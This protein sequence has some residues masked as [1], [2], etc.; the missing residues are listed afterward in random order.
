MASGVIP[1]EREESAT[2][3]GRVTSLPGDQISC[4]AIGRNDVLLRWCCTAIVLVVALI[5]ID[6]LPVGVVHDDGM[7]TVLA[8]ALATGQGYRWINLPGAPAATHYPPGYPVLLAIIWRFMPSLVRAVMAFKV[9]NALL[10]ATVAY[11]TFTFA[12]SRLQ[13]SRRVAAVATLVGCAGVPMLVLSTIVMSETMFLALLMPAL[14]FA[15]RL[16]AADDPTLTDAMKL[17]LMGGAL[18][19]VR[20]HGIAFVV[21]VIVALL[22]HRHI[23]QATAAALIALLVA[24]PWQYFQLAHQ[25]DLPG[26]VR[27]D[28]GTYTG[29]LLKGAASGGERLAIY[30]I[31]ATSRELFG[32]FAALTT[33][34]LPLVSVRW[35]AVIA[36]LVMLGVGFVALWNRA[37]GTALFIAAYIGILMLWPFTP[38]RFVWGI[39]SLVVLAFVAGARSI[40][41]WKPSI[42]GA[43]ALQIVVATGT[44]F[45][46]IAHGVYTA[47]GYR[48]RFWASIPR[49][50]TDIALPTLAWVDA[51]T[52]K[53]AVIS[54][55]AEF[56]V[57]LYTGRLAVP[58]TSFAAGD[59]LGRPS[60]ASR[61]GALQSIL[62]TYRIDAVAIVANDSLERAARSMAAAPNPTLVLRD[63]VPGGLLLTPIVR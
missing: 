59:Y 41:Q 61:T 16:L 44:V 56:L 25:A 9:V 54:T 52:P 18:M 11:S 38:A 28:Y 22:L 62:R 27:G 50:T 10:L 21:A 49:S 51:H 45:A 37:R 48:G 1:S 2:L 35:F 42:K 30:A 36:T 58:A 3:S 17:G 13:L 60:V 40:A 31:A 23:R 32:M 8:K 63:S 33:P 4:R 20:T 34:G 39:W 55:N 7:Y 15:D 43:K 6:S 26:V 19:L 53:S 12:V 14:L 47:R 29:W 24:L 5:A 57:Y 46:L